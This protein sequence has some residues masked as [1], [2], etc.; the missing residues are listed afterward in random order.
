MPTITRHTKPK[1]PLVQQNTT[2]RMT[3]GQAI[4]KYLSV[5]QTEL[6]NGSLSSLCGGIF[7]IFGHGN[8]T[9]LGEAIYQ[10]RNLL[11]Y[12]RGQNEQS[13]AHAAIAFAKT[14]RCRRMMAVT[15][16]IGPGATN[17]L[18]A[19]ATAHVNRLPVLFLPGDIFASRLPDPVLQQLENF[20]SPLDSVNDCFRPVSRY[21]DRITRP[22][23][24]LQTLPRAIQTLT[25]PAQCGPVTLCLPQDVQTE[26]YDF[27]SEFFEPKIHYLMRPEGDKRQFFQAYQMI[28]SSKKPLIIAGGGVHYSGATQALSELS[29]KL[30]IPVAE[31]QAGKGALAWDAAFNLGGIGV[32]GSSAANA[33]A[34]EADLIICI[35][36]RLSDFT[37]ASRTLFEN[38]EAKFMNINT[39]HWDAFKHTSFP[40]IC[41][42]KRAI[43]KITR[44]LA[45]HSTSDEYKDRCRSE[46]I[47]WNEL[48]AKATA[49]TSGKPND[50]QVLGVVNKAAGRS[51]IVVCAAGGLPGELHKLWR[52]ST[53]DSYHVEY[54]Y[55]CMGY[56]IAGGLG[57]K[58]AKPGTEVFVLVG[59]GSYLMMHT[60]LLTARQLDMKI[61]VIVLDNR[62]FGCID[63][64]QKSCGSPSFGN[65]F[66]ED[67]DGIDYVANAKSYG[68]HA[69][70][71]NN[72]V[73]LG[74]ILIAN[75]AIKNTCVTVIETDPSQSTPGTAW[76]NVPIA[77]CSQVPEVNSARETYLTKIASLN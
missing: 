46:I 19:A 60:E 34:K 38:P 25:N 5:Q 3:V 45:R 65:L 32:T 59:D 68:C 71:A 73:E 8:V 22:E 15:S 30:G 35:G 21:F 40:L 52:V 70:K 63:R 55:S 53:S 20:S 37:T 54:G 16:S 9:G 47:K 13:M 26:A 75:R 61:N 18:T 74:Q 66:K 43:V 14:F 2:L 50:A 10:Y 17:M 72:L 49:Y 77:A 12:F 6:I 44:N 67:I 27:P 28:K 42:A 1:E 69:S 57:V 31:T 39:C 29:L 58:I 4:L 62:G 11:P 33:I 23:Q 36:T 48:H 24:L 51:T 41:D 76:W 7:G 56:E 64:L